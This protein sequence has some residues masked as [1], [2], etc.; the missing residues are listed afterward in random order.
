MKQYGIRKYIQTIILSLG[1]FF[2]SISCSHAAEITAVDFKG[3]VIGKIISTGMVISPQEGNIGYITA[4]S[5]VVSN[6]G[7]IIGGVVPQG[8]AIGVDNKTL[9]K[10]HSDGVIRSNTGKPLGKALPNGLVVDEQY[11]VIG[12]ILFPGLIYSPQGETIGRLTGAGTYTNLDGAEIGFVSANGYAYRKNG[13]DYVLDGRLMSSKMVVSLTGQFIGSIAPSGKVIDFEGAE[14]GVIH[15]NE[16]VYNNTGTIIGRVVNTGYAFN[17]KGQ[18]IGIITY[19]GTVVQGEEEIGH[20]RADGYIVNSEN[21]VIGFSVSLA[22]TANDNNGNYLGWVLPNG[23]VVRGST[24]IGRVGA[25]GFIYD[26]EN[27]KI[28]Q[29]NHVGPVFGELGQLKGQSMRN[30]SYISLRGST[31]GKMKGRWAFDSNGMLAGGLSR[32]MLAY[33][34][35]NKALGVANIDSS[36]VD[37]ND[38]QKI[39]PFGYVL[40][41]ENKVNGGGFVMSPIYGLEGIVY[42]YLDPNGTLYR[43]MNEVKIDMNGTMI[44]KTG[45]VGSQLDIL[46]ALGYRSRQL[47]DLVSNN[48]IIN[49]DGAIAY[50]IT[51]GYYIVDDNGGN[52]QNLMPL[53]G[54][55]GTDMIAVGTS[56]DLLGYANTNGDIIDLSG[57]VFGRINYNGYVSDNNNSV[58]GKMIPF[59]S[60]YNDKC[61]IIGVV[62]GRGEV[63]NNRDVVVGRLLPN[64]Q[65]ISDVGAYIGY[66]VLSSGLVDFDGNYAGTINLGKG[67]DYENK[68]LGCV[69]RKG[70]IINSDNQTQYGIIHLDPVIDFNNRIIGQVLDNGSVADGDS[71]ILGHMQPNGTVISKSKKVLGNVMRYKVAFTNTNEFLGMVQGSGEVINNEGKTVGAISFDGSVFNEGDEIGYSLYDWYVYDEN[72]VIAGYIMK[73]G[74]VLNTSGNRLGK[75]DRGFVADRSGRVVARGNRDYTVRDS[76]NNSVGQLHLDGT[77]FDYNGQN[78]GYLADMGS[79][80]NVS[81]EEIAK[82]FPLQYYI[83][84]LQAEAP[85]NAKQ[86]WADYKQVQIQDDRKSK[87]DRQDVKQIIDTNAGGSFNRRVIGIALNPDGDV[88]GSIYDDNRVYDE[89]GNQVGFRTPDGMIVDM[90]YNPIGVEEIKNVSAQNMFVPA[91]TFGSGNAYGIG[92]RPS[93]LGP[94]GGYGAGERYDPAKASALQQLHNNRR[95]RINVKKISSNH[96]VSDFTGYEDDSWPNS[97]RVI[98]SWRVDMSEMILEDKPI[99]AVLARSVYASDGLGSNIPV[100]AIVERNVYSEEGR[101]I[102]IPAGSRVI[103][104]MGGEAGSGGVSGGAVKVGITWKRLIRP[105]GSQF[106]LSSA[107]TADAQ[108]RAGAIGYLD[109]QLLKKYTSPLL[110]TALESSVAYVMADGEGSSTSDGG[111]TTEDSRSQAASDARDNFINQMNSIFEE[112]LESKANIRSVT[113]IP[114]GTRI[115]IFP[116][117]DMWLNSEKR[118]KVKNEQ[119]FNDNTGLTSNKPEQFGAQASNVTYN[120]EYEEDIRPTGGG[121]TESFDTNEAELRRQQQLI[122]QRKLLESQGGKVPSTIQQQPVDTQD[123]VPSLL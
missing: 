98:S 14:I 115:I 1:V 69:N 110:L 32:D 48:I 123:D 35:Q 40:T 97:D 66:A 112:I 117:Q 12:S 10:V 33:N 23:I 34:A 64:G 87:T 44:G 46:Y 17:L 77:V 16:Y 53:R 95:S 28:G 79:I 120:G 78:I 20:F 30:G 116:N 92:S 21:E 103:G 41:A 118:S 105:D 45:Y 102:I 86:D 68:N 11:N 113:Y 9:G 108:G 18:Y 4:D 121:L 39:S 27:N 119:E 63:V 94:G 47:G 60:V 74:T 81:G 70:Q 73:D 85:A 72:F 42:S 50:K 96:K 5:F 51:P 80:R 25:R 90:Q 8:I 62:N 57:N 67:F 84:T 89:Q 65:A 111:T 7:A 43:E 29:I 122:R 59:T 88:I 76:S 71:Q 107:Q 31:I 106:T 91:G 2:I 93:S 26:T 109:E 36:T 24:E 52:E 3:N 114:A 15:A 100:T 13:D 99:P 56:G 75:I 101:N 55:A 58:V 49:K 38:K 37:G 83:A 6:D 61:A 82:A 19:N 54:F 104:Q 22:S